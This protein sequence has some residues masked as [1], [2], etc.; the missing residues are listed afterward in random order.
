MRYDL[1][2]ASQLHTSRDLIRPATEPLNEIGRMLRGCKDADVTFV[3]VDPLAHDDSATGE[4]EVAVAWTL[5][6]IIV[7]LTATTEESAA[8]AAELARGVAYHGR[9][10][11]ELPWETVTTVAQCRARL[12]ESRRMRL[13]SLGM[14]PDVPDLANSYQP[15]DG[16]PDH[17]ALKRFMVGVRHEVDHLAQI[18]D[19]IG[20]ARACRRRQTWWWRLFHPGARGNDLARL[21]E[22]VAQGR[23][24]APADEEIAGGMADSPHE[25]AE[26]AER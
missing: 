7:H 2:P 24:S 19:V 15:W 22:Q 3:P 25:V 21:S 9:S 13:A 17:N 1:P 14:W 5:G 6:H 16:A 4:G 12:E 10:R 11:N 8:L 23:A 20:Q 18:R 26:L